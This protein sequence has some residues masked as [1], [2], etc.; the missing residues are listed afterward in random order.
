MKEKQKL[1]LIILVI[2]F[3][4]YSSSQYMTFKRQMSD[5]CPLGHINQ[6]VTAMSQ[7]Q[8][9]SVCIAEYSCLGY[10]YNPIARRCKTSNSSLP[11]ATANALSDPGSI[12]LWTENLDGYSRFGGMAYRIITGLFDIYFARTGCTLYGGQL[13]IPK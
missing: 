11:T 10:C 12:M 4:V 9:S 2:T 13:V 1:L 7:V 6:V 3:V 5:L 8:C